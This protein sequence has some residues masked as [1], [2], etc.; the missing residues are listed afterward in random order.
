MGSGEGPGLIIFPMIVKN[1]VWGNIS[2]LIS[3][4]P[5]TPPLLLPFSCEM[6]FCYIA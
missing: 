4:L 1:E 5:Y 2:S 3:S 6:E